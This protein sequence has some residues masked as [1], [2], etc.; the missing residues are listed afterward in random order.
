MQY[1]KPHLQA[2]L[3]VQFHIMIWSLVEF[4]RTKK[5]KVD[6]DDDDDDNNNNK[7]HFD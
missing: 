7:T 6:D 1:I 2:R 4:G 5:R 3:G